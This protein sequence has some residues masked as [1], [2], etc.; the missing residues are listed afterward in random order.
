MIHDAQVRSRKR[1]LNRRASCPE[2]TIEAVSSLETLARESLSLLKLIGAQSFSGDDAMRLVGMV[3]P[4]R[5]DSK[6]PLVSFMYL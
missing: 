6:P 2:V 5:N 3:D 1:N 4:W